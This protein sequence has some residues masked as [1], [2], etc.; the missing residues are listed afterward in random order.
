MKILHVIPSISPHSGGPAYALSQYANMAMDWAE[1]SIYT[2][3]EG[4]EAKEGT[5]QIREYWKLASEVD[6]RC[7]EYKG[8]HSWKRSRSLME[9]LSRETTSF[10]VLHIHA[11]FSWISTQTARWADKQGIPFIRRPLGT[12][13]AY[14]RSAG[15]RWLKKIYWELQEKQ[16]LS[17]S[18]QIHCTS[19][20]EAD[21]VHRLMGESVNTAVVPISID[22]PPQV[23]SSKHSDHLKLGYLGRIHPKK[24]LELLFRAMAEVLDPITLSIA[25]DGEEAYIDDLKQLSNQLGVAQQI[26][27][28]GFVS[29]E[30]KSHFFEQIDWYVLPSLHENFGIAVVEALAQ[31]VPVIISDQVDVADEIKNATAGLIHSLDQGELIEK[32]TRACQISEEMYEEY[33]VHARQLAESKFSREMISQK[34]NQ[35]YRDCVGS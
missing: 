17:N 5:R 31:G 23:K 14:S 4:W 21:E 7:F 32:L 33:H 25:G 19:K 24:N 9:A 34:L 2:T 3:W 29:G 22:I 28:K 16:T 20:R 15:M 8:T 10:D 27:W 30:E 1:V 11:C 18:C 26:E 13:S 6:L 12:L 35:M